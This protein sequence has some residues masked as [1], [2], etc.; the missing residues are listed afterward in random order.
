[1][2]TEKGYEIILASPSEY[3]GLV[4]EIY[5]D[6]LYVATIHQERGP[7]LFAINFPGAGLDETRLAREVDLSGF[8]N[9]VREASARLGSTGD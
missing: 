4:A 7:G 8:V 1:M 5:L 6:G 2:L 9:A 3:E